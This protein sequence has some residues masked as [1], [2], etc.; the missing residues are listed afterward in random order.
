MRGNVYI[1]HCIPLWSSLHI[2]I[3][4]YTR[5]S[6]SM[7]NGVCRCLLSHPLFRWLIENGTSMIYRVSV[8]SQ[9][10]ISLYTKLGV[11]LSQLRN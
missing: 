10:F 3:V 7:D 2:Q 8:E 1:N 5:Q 4:Q 6:P 11:P 9:Y